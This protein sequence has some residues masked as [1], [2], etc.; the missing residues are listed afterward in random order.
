MD[1]GTAGFYDI[2]LRGTT[3]GNINADLKVQIYVCDVEETN[4]V[5]LFNGLLSQTVLINAPSTP[6]SAAKPEVN[7]LLYPMFTCT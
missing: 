3:A 7:Y 1:Q 4:Y 2:Y 6:A 5:A